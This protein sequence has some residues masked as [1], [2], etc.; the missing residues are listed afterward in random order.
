MKAIRVIR[1]AELEAEYCAAEVPPVEIQHNFASHFGV[2]NVGGKCYAD[3]IAL[4]A[5]RERTVGL[6]MVLNSSAD[7][8]QRVGELVQAV[9]A[10]VMRAQIRGVWL[11]LELYALGPVQNL[12]R[13]GDVLTTIA[14]RYDGDGVDETCEHGRYDSTTEY[15]KVSNGHY[16]FR[17]DGRWSHVLWGSLPL[18]AEI[19]G[20]VLVTDI[21]GHT[22]KMQ[23]GRIVLTEDPRYVQ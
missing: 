11:M 22:A 19:Q 18:P 13:V 20:N 4:G 2:L 7:G 3:Q 16:N 6:P 17:V 1:F 10:H 23:A 9:D 8:T 21:W 14:E 12:T 5:P 15:I